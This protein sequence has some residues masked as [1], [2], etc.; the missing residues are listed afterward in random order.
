MQKYAQF[1]VNLQ[2]HTIPLLSTLFVHFK[3]YY[4]F[5]NQF[6]PKIAQKLSFL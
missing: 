5:F 2:I 1:I 4:L 6:G 3:F